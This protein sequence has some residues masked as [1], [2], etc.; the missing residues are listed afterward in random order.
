VVTESKAMAAQGAALLERV[1]IE[2]DL[3]QLSPAQRVAYYRQVCESLGIN[4]LTKPFDYI[5]L[6]GRLTLYAKKDAT[7]QLRKRDG[8][9]IV[10]PLVTQVIN[11]TY[12]VT[13]TAAVNGRTDISTGAVSIKG[14]SGDHLANAMMKAETKAKRRVTLSIC[15]LGMLDETEVA[16]V[17]EAQPVVVTPAGE[18]VGNG[19]GEP[20]AAVLNDPARLRKFW[21]WAKSQ[22]LDEN[23]VHT[24][25]NVKSLKDET[26]T[27]QQVMDTLMAYA[28]SKRQAESEAD[29][30]ETPE[31]VQA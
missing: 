28:E 24:A 27:R 20:F 7:D 9:S 30:F 29:I 12:V 17:A 10:P 21:Q 16:D 15:G 31:A 8:V 3:S 2:G 14:L 18:I 4:P 19:H 22:G 26:G 1:V 6:N 11:D 13:A 5:T 23:D 25:L